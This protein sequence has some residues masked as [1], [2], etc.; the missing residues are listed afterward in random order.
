M[1]SPKAGIVIIHVEGI[2]GERYF[3]HMQACCIQDRT[4]RGKGNQGF[5]VKVCEVFVACRAYGVHGRYNQ[6]SRE[7]PKP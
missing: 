3:R 7:E 5:R 2:N 1:G 4:V 6:S